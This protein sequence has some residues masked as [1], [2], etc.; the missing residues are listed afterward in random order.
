[1][2]FNFVKA[3][4]G[5]M[6]SAETR[7]CGDGTYVVGTA[8]YNVSGVLEI[9]SG[10][11]QATH[12]SLENKTLAADGDMLVYEV[13]PTMI[14]EC[15]IED[16]DATYHAVGKVAGFHTDGAQITDAAAG[17]AYVAATSGGEVT[18]ALKTG[19][20]ALILDMRGA[21]ADGDVC[22]VRLNHN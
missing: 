2:A 9:A 21:A 3:T 20:G 10:A 18:T 22:W 13:S 19:T 14:H 16:L 11:V 15:P 4:D 1:M 12:I 5:S 7:I 6:Y 17:V 8:L